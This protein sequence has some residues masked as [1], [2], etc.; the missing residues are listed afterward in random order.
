MKVEVDVQAITDTSDFVKRDFVLL[1]A[2]NW[3]NGNRYAFPIRL[4]ES[5]SMDG[6]IISFANVDDAPARRDVKYY[7]DDAGVAQ[8]KS[9][10]FDTS[11]GALVFDNRGRAFAVIVKSLTFSGTPLENMTPEQLFN[12]FSARGT[13]SVFPIEN[14]L[15]EIKEAI[16]P[17]SF[18]SELILRLRSNVDVNLIPGDLY[19]RATPIDLIHLIDAI[20]LGD[21]GKK[22][23]A[24]KTAMKELLSRVGSAAGQACVLSYEQTAF[25]T[26]LYQLH[27]QTGVAGPP[28]NGGSNAPPSV[29]R[30]GQSSLLRDP[31][32][33]GMHA[34]DVVELTQSDS[35]REIAAAGAMF[36][37]KALKAAIT[38][39]PLEES[40][41]EIA[42]GLLRRAASGDEL[43]D[44]MAK[45]HKDPELAAL[46]GNVALAEE[47]GVKHRFGSRAAARKSILVSS[48]LGGSFSAY[49][50]AA[51]YAIGE[52]DY[53]SSATLFARAYAAVRGTTS[54]E[55][56]VKSGLDRAFRAVAAQAGFSSSTAITDFRP[57]KSLFRN[58]TTWTDLAS[59]LPIAFQFRGNTFAI[60]EPV[61][62]Q[63]DAGVSDVEIKIGNIVPYSGPASAYGVI[64][65]TQAAYFKKINEAGGINGR[66]VNFISYDDGYLP[67]RTV[68]QVRKLVESDEVLLIFSSLGTPQNVAIQKYM[69]FKKVPQLFVATGAA[70][71]NDPRD[72]PWTMGWQPNYQVEGKIYAKYLLK[73]QPGAKIA[74]LF[75]NDEYGKDYVRGLKDELGAK[76]G[77]MIVAEESFEASEPTIDS[78]IVKLKSTGADVFFDITTPKFAAQAIKKAAE[79]QWKPLHILNNIATSVGSVIKPAGL[80]N[81]QGIISATYLKDASDP[82]WENDPGMK[83]FLEFLAKDFT[84]GNKLDSSVIVGY[85][86]A[87]T[88]VQV[89][90]QCGDNL[91]REN[92]MRQ[93]ASLKDFRTEV[94]LPGITINT[95][96]NDFAP[97]SQLQLMRFKGEKWELFGDIIGADV[98]GL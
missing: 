2:L 49:E 45:R 29:G 35:P 75:Q 57:P 76:A 37:D 13:I 20:I 41:V 70:R 32:P 6:H 94:L 36:L 34:S 1:R 91:T 68:E 60:N 17:G 16:P 97:I 31:E 82:Q 65:K 71:W 72:N 10:V 27:S 69:N 80:E 14:A 56:A 88:L 58:Q 83:Q 85:G 25:A 3:Q 96:P 43:R 78:R 86:V 79:I 21:V 63:Y 30:S 5:E 19:Q 40:L 51:N 8:F 23:S 93:A 92:I 53:L 9:N 15:P 81:A 33:P 90:K 50:L 62:K 74:I 64:G 11:S 84:E 66:R 44:A 89:L 47:L 98:G 22:W 55:R 28:Q 4:D 48:A 54:R 95:S 18:M 24:N 12:E 38:R 73:Q 77:T 67:Q 46:A 42:L 39:S 26:A 59:D 52:N 7:R 61:S 87:Q